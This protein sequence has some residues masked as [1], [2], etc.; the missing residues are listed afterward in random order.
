MN[1]TNLD[2]LTVST[3]KTIGSIAKT[4]FGSDDYPAHPDLVLSSDDST[5]FVFEEK[6][7]GEDSDIEWNWKLID[8]AT[9][10]ASVR[11]NFEVGGNM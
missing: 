3:K 11:S 9:N 8:A 4:S 10:N 1:D 6:A 5:I 7:R 2:K